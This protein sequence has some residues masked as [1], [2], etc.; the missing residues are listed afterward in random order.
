M[1]KSAPLFGI[2]A[3]V[4]VAAAVGCSS[5]TDT[6][7]ATLPGFALQITNSYQTNTYGF[8]G[9]DFLLTNNGTPVQGAKICALDHERIGGSSDSVVRDTFK[10]SGVVSVTDAN[11]TLNGAVNYLYMNGIYFYAVKDSLISDTLR[12]HP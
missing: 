12:W 5:S 1:K 11:G 6:T 8:Q 4:L 9:F 2:F 3:F 7:P 10:V